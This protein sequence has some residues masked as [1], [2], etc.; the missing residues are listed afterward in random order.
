MIF[1]YCYLMLIKL[2]AKLWKRLRQKNFNQIRTKRSKRS[3]GGVSQSVSR[4]DY[5]S[6]K[7]PS[8]APA[9][10]DK[11]ERLAPAITRRQCLVF[12]R[13]PAK[14]FSLLLHCAQY[15]IRKTVSHAARLNVSKVCVCAEQFIS[16]SC[17]W[18]IF[19][20]GDAS[21]F[22]DRLLKV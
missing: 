15:F 8:S 22:E 21:A 12:M 3:S 11:R 2:H 13:A 1:H 4:L 18:A 17:V 10:L 7:T 14:S 16:F 5:G 9:C 19:F 6:N 20:Q